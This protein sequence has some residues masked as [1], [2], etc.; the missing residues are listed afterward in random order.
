MITAL[1]ISSNSTMKITAIIKMKMEKLKKRTTSI[2]NY[3]I[4]TAKI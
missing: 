1:H 3:I 4:K 2:K